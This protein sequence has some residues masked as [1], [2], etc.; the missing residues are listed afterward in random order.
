MGPLIGEVEEGLC[1]KVVLCVPM[2]EIVGLQSASA[3]IRRRNE[4]A[5]RLTTMRSEKADR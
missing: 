4:H 3:R 5:Q 2:E 1:A